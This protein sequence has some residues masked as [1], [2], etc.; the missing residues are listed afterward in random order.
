MLTNIL[1][2]I[3]NIYNLRLILDLYERKT[4]KYPNPPTKVKVQLTK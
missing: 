2:K 3:Q 4:V 1:Y